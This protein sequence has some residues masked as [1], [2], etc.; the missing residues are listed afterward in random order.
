MLGADLAP[1]ASATLN[2]CQWLLANGCDGVG[3]LGTT[4]EGPSFTTGARRALVEAV[5]EGGVPGQRLIVGTGAAALIDAVELTRH[6]VDAGVAGCL[7]VPPFYFKNISDDGVYAFYAEL[8]ERV[9]R[10]GLRMYLY[11]FP[12]MSAVPISHGVIARLMGDFPGIVTGLKDS[13]GD[14]G[15]MLGLIEK[16]PGL[17]VFSGTERYLLG[18][19]E[20]GGV[21]CISAG[22]NVT[23]SAIGALYAHWREAGADERALVLQDRVIALRDVLEGVPM[24]PAMKA[25]LARHRDDSG[26]ALV[27]PPLVALGDQ[28][29]AAFLARMIEAGLELP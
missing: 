20:A 2:H 1:D 29:R 3:L 5:I 7:V 13:S 8:I 10:D 27:A 9:G 11:H 21:G 17:E 26:L 28:D 19:L 16:F 12:Q 14:F 6:G 15:N 4:G 23:S 24:I 18:V 22:A 25:M